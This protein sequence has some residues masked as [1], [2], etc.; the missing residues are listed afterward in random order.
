MAGELLGLDGMRRNT[1]TRT[2]VVMLLFTSNEI[3]RVL[4]GSSGVELACSRLEKTSDDS[5]NR[6]PPKR[7]HMKCRQAA[8]VKHKSEHELG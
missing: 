7:I 1:L 8:R 4:A 5:L 3:T 6:Q 2:S